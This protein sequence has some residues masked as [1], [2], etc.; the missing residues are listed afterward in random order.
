M[1]ERG[2]GRGPFAGRA[3][4]AG[5]EVREGE[6]ERRG[7]ARG[8][9]GEGQSGGWAAESLPARAAPGFFCVPSRCRFPPGIRT[10]SEL[11]VAM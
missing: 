4:A 10:R 7:E 3:R 2:A 8:G 5:A 6:R 11:G 9:G 1:S